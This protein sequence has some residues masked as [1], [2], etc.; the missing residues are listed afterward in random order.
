[1]KSAGVRCP[2]VH[3]E[4][5]A[6]HHFIIRGSADCPEKPRVH[7]RVEVLDGLHV[8][9]EVDALLP[10]LLLLQLDVGG[11]IHQATNLGVGVQLP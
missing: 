11:G 1:M 6:W 4:V 2:Y 3:V 5:N 9:C 8:H 10:E 7:P